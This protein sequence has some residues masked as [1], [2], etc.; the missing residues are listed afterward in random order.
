[1]Q[2]QR[3]PSDWIEAVQNRLTGEGKK[4]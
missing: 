4:G 1:M 2:A 3:I